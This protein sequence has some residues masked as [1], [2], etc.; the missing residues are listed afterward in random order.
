MKYFN[1]KVEEWSIN[2]GDWGGSFAKAD[3]RK[4]I[5][6]KPLIFLLLLIILI[7]SF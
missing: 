3:N 7:N 4:R 6:V 5:I 1:K 2:N